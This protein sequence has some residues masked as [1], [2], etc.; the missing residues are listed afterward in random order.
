MPVKFAAELIQAGGN[1]SLYEQPCDQRKMIVW[2]RGLHQMCPDA[3]S[4]RTD[5]VISII[6]YL[7][8]GTVFFFFSAGNLQGSQC[9]PARHIQFARCRAPSTNIQIKKENARSVEEANYTRCL[10]WSL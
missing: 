9:D 4:L 7:E 10:H 2:W 6:I 3:P 1:V 5:R 8:S